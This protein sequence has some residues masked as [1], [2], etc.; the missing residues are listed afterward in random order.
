[1]AQDTSAQPERPVNIVEL[2]EARPDGATRTAASTQSSDSARVH[3]GNA[4]VM[5]NWDA[6]RVGMTEEDVHTL[7]GPPSHRQTLSVLTYWFYEVGT[8]YIRPHVTFDDHQVYG[9]AAP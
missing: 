6:L 8:A 4:A 3:L 7:L 2:K 9:W 1:M 5:S